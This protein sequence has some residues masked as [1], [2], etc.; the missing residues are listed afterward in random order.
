V[1]LESYSDVVTLRV[2]A[3]KTKELN[4]P[5]AKIFLKTDTQVSIVPPSK[6]Q[7]FL[8][9]K[10][11]KKELLKKCLSPTYKYKYNRNINL[12]TEITEKSKKDKA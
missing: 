6:C 4:T 5:K 9:L 2:L 7:V 1:V 10:L 12:F 11:N 8:W 3:H